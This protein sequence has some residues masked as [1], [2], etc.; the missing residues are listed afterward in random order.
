MLHLNICYYHSSG[1]TVL[2][3]RDHFLS[4]FVHFMP[5]LESSR[6]LLLFHNLRR[7]AVQIFFPY[8]AA[9]W[10]AVALAYLWRNLPSQCLIIYQTMRLA[11]RSKQQQVL[12]LLLTRAKTTKPFNS[13][14]IF[15]TGDLLVDPKACFIEMSKPLNG[16]HSFSAAAAAHDFLLSKQ[17]GLIM[18]IARKKEE[19]G[20]KCRKGRE[21]NP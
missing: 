15:G 11:Q 13:Q 7:T 9:W 5:V 10:V 19:S 2:R 6:W 8:P 12:L 17:K 1:N 4:G 16:V 14:D 3:C 21:R 20:K 18:I